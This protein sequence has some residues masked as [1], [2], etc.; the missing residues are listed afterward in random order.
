MRPLR[1]TLRSTSGIPYASWPISFREGFR[2]LFKSDLGFNPPH[3]ARKF[4]ADGGHAELFLKRHAEIE[5]RAFFEQPPPQRDA[6]GNLE[7]AARSLVLSRRQLARAEGGCAARCE[8]KEACTQMQAR[9]SGEVARDEHRSGHEGA[10]QRVNFAENLVKR[11][12]DLITQPIQLDVIYS[13][14][15][16]RLTKGVWPGAVVLPCERVV[17]IGQ[18]QVLERGRG[19]RVEHVHERLVG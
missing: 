6:L 4:G 11:Q 13:R 18:G 19:F 17:E 7:G 8:F 14:K 9:M 2:S 5:D 3:T 15:K 12:H 10:D 16:A 1:R